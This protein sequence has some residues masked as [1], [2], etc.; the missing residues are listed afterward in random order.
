MTLPPENPYQSPLA[1]LPAPE[2]PRWSLLRG[3]KW[4]VPLGICGFCVPYAV[5]GTMTL[6]QTVPTSMMPA[7]RAEN[8]RGLAG[9]GLEAAV[10]CAVFF[11]TAAF[12]N[13]APRRGVGLGR[14]LLVMAQFLLGAFC[15][16]GVVG[17]IVAPDRGRTYIPSGPDE[18]VFSV[19][20]FATYLAGAGFF[21]YWQI[22]RPDA[23]AKSDSESSETTTSNAKAG[24]Q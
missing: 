20:F 12:A 18:W 5:L 14:S 22:Q 24:P 15:L 1:E 11:A 23:K 9:Q 13:F 21:T 8:N 17:A 3:L 16:T 10:I 7:E 19:I 2:K 6:F 4:A